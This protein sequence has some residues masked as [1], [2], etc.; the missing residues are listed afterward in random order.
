M[1]KSDDKVLSKD[2]GQF[3]ESINS[4]TLELYFDLTG[5]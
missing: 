2:Y 5:S 3:R 4:Y 1:K